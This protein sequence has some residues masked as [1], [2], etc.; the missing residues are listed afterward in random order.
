M[1]L[2]ST[3]L[4]GFVQTVYEVDRD[5]IEHNAEQIDSLV[6]KLNASGGEVIRVS[7]R[8]G[9]LDISISG[10]KAAL[11]KVFGILRSAGLIPTQPPKEG[12]VNYSTFWEPENDT[13]LA[14]RVWLSFTSTQC[15]MVEVGKETIIRPIYE[16]VCE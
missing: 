1:V 3:E 6:A 15:R 10:N 9:S 5:L 11:N 4:L 12:T 16:V 7:F 13:A 2:N 8:D 14:L